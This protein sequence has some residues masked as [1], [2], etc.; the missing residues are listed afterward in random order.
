MSLHHMCFVTCLHA[1]DADVIE[2]LGLKRKELERS[3]NNKPNLLSLSSQ[4]LCFLLVKVNNSYLA[5]STSLGS[6]GLNNLLLAKQRLA[7]SN[8]GTATRQEMASTVGVMERNL[9]SR[10]I[11]LL[12]FCREAFRNAPVLSQVRGSKLK[13]RGDDGMCWRQHLFVGEWVGRSNTRTTHTYAKQEDG[14]ATCD[15]HTRHS[16]L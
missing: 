11:D 8:F 15:F 1:Q 3:L 5:S 16:A 6:V 4:G 2:R 14:Q 13:C 12:E 9:H 7:T 10:T